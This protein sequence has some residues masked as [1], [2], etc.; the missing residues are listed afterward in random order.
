MAPRREWIWIILFTK[1]QLWD[2]FVIKTMEE[3]RNSEGKRTEMR[4]L[5]E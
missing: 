4:L 1:K 2:K 5:A 3:V